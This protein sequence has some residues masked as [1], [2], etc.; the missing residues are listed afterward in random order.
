M[1]PVL[2]TLLGIVYAGVTVAILSLFQDLYA[3]AVTAKLSLSPFILF[4]AWVFTCLGVGYLV[5]K[6]A[7]AFIHSL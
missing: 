1:K 4:F 7:F 5:M 3:E 6:R 2:Y